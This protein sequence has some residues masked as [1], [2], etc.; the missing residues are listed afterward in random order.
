MRPS[1]S[2]QGSWVTQKT[3]GTAMTSN[4]TMRVAMMTA[5][6]APLPRHCSRERVNPAIE[7]TTSPT[8][9]IP[10]DTMSEL[11]MNCIAGTRSKTAA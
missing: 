3:S 10:S 4:G 1:N 9:T 5:K 8:T 2:I 11:S 7:L 6:T